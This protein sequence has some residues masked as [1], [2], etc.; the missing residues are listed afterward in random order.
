MEI[1]N[2]FETLYSA[3]IERGVSEST[4]QRHIKLLSLSIKEDELLNASSSEDDSYREINELADSIALILK[5]N[6]ESSSENEI[7]L[8]FDTIDSLEHNFLEKSDVRDKDKNSAP[9]PNDDD[10][11]AETSPISQIA[12]CV[13]KI[14]LHALLYLVLGMVGIILILSLFSVTIIGT[15]TSIV[16]VVYGVTQLFSFPASGI[17]EIGLA[18]VICGV[19]VAVGVTFHEVAKTFIPKLQKK[20]TAKIKSL[21]KRISKICVIIKRRRKT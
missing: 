7:L 14:V 10:S 11:I 17:Y 16:G 12:S 19:C 5:R 8:N 6:G 15:A 20:I 18:V 21:C 4:A 13:G 2:Y 9:S 1:N 3:L